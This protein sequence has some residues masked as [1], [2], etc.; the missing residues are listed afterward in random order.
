MRM[1]I[2]DRYIGQ[3]VIASTVTVLIVLLAIF[4]FF[5]FM[6]ELEDIG[7]GSYTLGRAALVIFLSV[8]GL[9][10]ELFP[11]A[12]LLGALL[13]LGSMM[14]R[15]EIAVVR[16]AG[17][18]KLRVIG[19]VMKTGLVFVVAAVLIGEL[20]FRLSSEERGGGEGGNPN[21]SGQM[22]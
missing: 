5:A 19:S 10:Y 13:G 21:G 22:P 18:S 17:V 15:N 4:T 8:P 7:R 12:A 3:N 20:V 9:A 6:D 11:I 16:A 1:K 2:V 14:E